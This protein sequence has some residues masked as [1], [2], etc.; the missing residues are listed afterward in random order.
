MLTKVD[1]LG[2]ALV[3]A[4][5]AGVVDAPPNELT[6]GAGFT[7]RFTGAENT[8][9]ATFTVAA[10]APAP[11]PETVTAV[12]P[13][14]I[15]VTCAGAFPDAVVEVEPVVVVA[16]VVVVVATVLVSV[17]VEVVVDVLVEVVVVAVVVVV[18]YWSTAALR[19][20]SGTIFLTITIFFGVV[21]VTTTIFFAGFLT[22]CRYDRDTFTTNPPE[23]VI[24]Y[25]SPPTAA[26]PMTIA[27]VSSAA[28]YAGRTWRRL[29]RCPTR[30]ASVRTYSFRA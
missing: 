20:G 11:D 9:G 14:G 1:W 18:P 16:S 21:T 29:G 5:T 3:N 19:F 2:G 15:T 6:P 27:A 17:V 22:T 25:P 10:G 7:D 26:R 23:R 12:D 24:A 4:C 8:V 30:A 13:P 28:R